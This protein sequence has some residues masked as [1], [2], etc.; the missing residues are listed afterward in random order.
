MKTSRVWTS[1]ACMVG[2][3]G[4]PRRRWLWRVER[5]IGMGRDAGGR[6]G[7]KALPETHTWLWVRAE[8][9]IGAEGMNAMAGGCG[10]REG[11]EGSGVGV[12]QD[13]R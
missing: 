4:G 5:G 13:W 1:T 6:A 10:A 12:A 8:E 3:R 7:M 2:A 11:E 9:R